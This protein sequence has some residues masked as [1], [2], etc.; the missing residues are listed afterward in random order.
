MQNDHAPIIRG[1][2]WKNGPHHADQWVKTPQK[3]IWD[4]PICKELKIQIEF[5]FKFKF[6]LKQKEK[7]KGKIGKKEMAHPTWAGLGQRPISLLHGP[8]G[9]SPLGQATKTK[10]KENGRAPLDQAQGHLLLH[11]PGDR[12]PALSELAN[13]AN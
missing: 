7:E 13:T 11:G 10:E 1:V 6:E 8:T 2:K 9:Q 12:G 4:A 5:E 3:H